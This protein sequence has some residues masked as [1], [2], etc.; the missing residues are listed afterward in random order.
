MKKKSTLTLIAII[1][2]IVLIFALFA[3]SYNS[4]VD[5]KES[6][7]SAASTISTYLQR[8]ADLI[9]NFVNTVKGYSDYESETYLAV[10]E[11]RSAVAKANGATEQQAASEQ[12]DKAISIWVNAVTENYPQLKASEQ[13]RALTVELEGSENR[14]ATARK[15]Y[16]D[17]VKTYNTSIK[18]FPRNIM[19]AIFGFEAYDYFQA[20]ES[21]NQVPQVNFD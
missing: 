4:M 8:R 10:T 21:A 19:A 7:E 20:D 5:R 17:Q 3:G 15:D 14:I 16:N 18:K 9:P 11:A 2:A 13:Y 12:L 1:A 6:V